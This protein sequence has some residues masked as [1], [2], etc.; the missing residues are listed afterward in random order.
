MKDSTFQKLVE[1][2]VSEETARIEYQLG[3]IARRI[4]S[5]QQAAK[6]LRAS[7]AARKVEVANK[8][9]RQLKHAG[10][11]TGN[12]KIAVPVAELQ[13]ERGE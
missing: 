12:V 6:D 4:S 3:K 9:A 11:S 5:L 10:S 2:E 1:S 13:V 7:A 8:L